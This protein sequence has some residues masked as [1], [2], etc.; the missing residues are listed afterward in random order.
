MARTRKLVAGTFALAALALAAL[1]IAAFG[2]LRVLRGGDR[3]L[4]EFEGS[5]YGLEDGANVYMNGVR[6]GAVDGLAVAPG[7]PDRVRIRIVVGAGTPVRTDT[8]AML[9][10]AGI[11]GLKVID[12]RGGSAGAPALAP[13]GTI[14]AGETIFDKLERRAEDLADQSAV[15]MERANTI[16]GHLA[17]V[18][19][20]EGELAQ[21][22]R[23]GAADLAAAGTT[24]RAIA[25]E[26][27]A[28]IRGSIDAVGQ[29]ARG[30]DEVVAQLRGLL[31]DLLR[32]NGPALRA[33][34]VDL[35]QASR[36]LKDLAREVRQR[37]SRL[38]F[39]EAPRE[40]RL[41]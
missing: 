20:P 2:G 17:E 40:R 9:Q 21:A 24:L 8:R 41:P 22:A 32:D 6:V 29:T 30:A 28:R 3:Y 14:T 1:V 39:S 35:R 11:T 31:R 37:P 15:M 33:S 19:D 4:V 18:T 34:L 25:D 36:T 5:V 13:G 26:N 23:R 16:L 27:R 7:D 12:L 38:L 10:L